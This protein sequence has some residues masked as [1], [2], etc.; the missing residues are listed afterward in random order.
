VLAYGLVSITMFAGFLLFAVQLVA[1]PRPVYAVFLTDMDARFYERYW[2]RL[3]PPS[4][5]VFDPGYSRSQTIFGRQA[6]SLA[7]WG[8]F[9]PEFLE[10][11]EEPNPYQLNAAGYSYIYADK[12][13]WK[14]YA[15]Q[16]S[17][18]C[19][20]VLETIEGARQT[21]SGSAPDFRQLADISECR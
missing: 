14:E 2:D 17:Q 1:I 21:Q 20:Q 11:V 16:L 6:D 5:W 15:E 8:V 13:Y 3:S 9:T 4:A 18:P 7:R 12:D 19:V 10:L